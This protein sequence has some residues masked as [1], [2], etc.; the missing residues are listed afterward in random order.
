MVRRLSQV[1]TPSVIA[2]GL[3]I[4]LVVVPVSLAPA[5]AQ[6]QVSS[7]AL[8]R[9]GDRGSAVV[10]LQKALIRA[11]IT[12][13]GGADGVFG[14]GTAGALAQFQRSAGLNPTG[15]L[16]PTAA[17]LLGLAPAPALRLVVS[18]V[19]PCEPFRTPWSRRESRY[20]AASTAFS[21]RALQP[22]CRPS[23]RPGA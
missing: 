3:S 5:S 12:V 9:Q 4:G 15:V 14:R 7:T 6:T 1:V 17:H 2:V 13:P 11:G 8:P 22:R 16:D 18:G 20:A 21:E 19:M 23:K 10:N